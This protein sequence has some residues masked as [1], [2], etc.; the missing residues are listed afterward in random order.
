MPCEVSKNNKKNNQQVPVMPLNIRSTIAPDIASR[1]NDTKTSLISQAQA[2]RD[3][4]AMAM[5]NDNRVIVT[6]EGVTDPRGTFGTTLDLVDRFGKE[7]VFDAPLSENC[8]AGVCIGA[9][10]SGLR[11]I[12]VFSRIEFVLLAMDQ[13][14]NNASRWQAIFGGE[15]TIPLVIRII[16]G[17]G[18]GIDPNHSRDLQN[19]IAQIPGMKSVM[20]TTAYDAKGL[21]LSAIADN[22]PVIVLEHRYLHDSIDDVPDSY[23][24]LPLTQSEQVTEGDHITVAAFSYSVLSAKKAAQALKPFGLN[25][26]VINMRSLNPI[27]TS[28]LCESV[29]K[30]GRLMIVDTNIQHHTIASM[31]IN[32]VLDETF[33]YLTKPPVVM[34]ACEDN[35]DLLLGTQTTTEAIQI[36]KASVALADKETTQ[37][38]NLPAVLHALTDTLDSDI[39]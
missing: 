24:T 29:K 37:N 19:L 17:R 26:E 38:V 21:M 14:V 30:T 9:A 20:P 28:Q 18:Y 12:L 10:L 32:K 34:D 23:Y 35:T 22:D 15:N 8:M 31:L 39:G 6:G 1:M 16:F 36:V 5:E 2:I 27:D 4:T 7:R 25:L 13:L 11:P 3:A 33:Y